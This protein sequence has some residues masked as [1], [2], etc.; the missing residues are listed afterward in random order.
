MWAFFP[1]VASLVALFAYPCGASSASRRHPCWHT[2][3]KSRFLP[4]MDA[5]SPGRESELMPALS[6]LKQWKLRISEFD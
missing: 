1:E 4:Q 2:P 5:P 3:L 6:Q